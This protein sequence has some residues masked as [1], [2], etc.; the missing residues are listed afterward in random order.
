MTGDSNE[1]LTWSWPAMGRVTLDNG[2][3]PKPAADRTKGHPDS[4]AVKQIEQCWQAEF[5]KTCITRDPIMAQAKE[6][7]GS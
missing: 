7:N 6:K 1:T 5:G 4:R 2:H 3:A